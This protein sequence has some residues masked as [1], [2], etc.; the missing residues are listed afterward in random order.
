VVTI[1]ELEATLEKARERHRKLLENGTLKASLQELTA[2]G[3]FVLQAER[4]LAAAKNEE[5]AAP[6]D[7]P[8]R[9]DTGAPLPH[10]LQSDDRTFVFFLLPDHESVANEKWLQISTAD[11]TYGELIG[12]VEFEHCRCSKMGEPNDEVL[13]GH[14][15]YGKGL[16]FYGA[17]S[18]E[19]SNW[20]KELEAIN[21]V[22]SQY[23][24]EAWKNLKHLILC[25]HDSTFEC[26]ARGFRVEKW[27][28]SIPA[29]L[30][31]VCRRLTE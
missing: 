26:V 12:L 29:M 13:H 17:F 25:F 6:L 7:F 14:P 21:S 11:A 15:L 31:E 27:K 24:Q 28:A 1:R 30:V 19:N 20:I 3:E 18:V 10:L 2:S 8:V 9:W 4:A 23:K 16:S 5:Y 22:H